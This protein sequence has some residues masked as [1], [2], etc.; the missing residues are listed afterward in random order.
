MLHALRGALRRTPLRPIYKTIKRKLRGAGG[1]SQSDESAIIDRLIAAEDAPLT[2]VEFGFHPEEFNCIGLVKRA[3]GGLLIDG[4]SESIRI[5]KADFPETIDAVTRFL[6]LDNID[7]IRTKFDKLGILSIDVDGNDY[8]F[9]EALID[10]KPTIIV[11]EYNASMGLRSLTVPYDPAFE[12][13]AKHPSGWYHGAS[14][15]ALSKLAARHG[16][17]LAA[18]SSA[19]LNL[20][21][22]RNGKL[23]PATA[24][25]PSTL[26][27]KW[28]GKTVDQQWDAIA[29]LPFVEI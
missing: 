17:G 5:A 13:H 7:F 29:A 1:Q 16:Y 9:L 12:R 14:I 15:T 8:W 4:D 26:R 19:G 10:I 6:T 27:E 23:D 20:F 2:F 28:S 21:F 18:V 11:V 22:T 24:W 25:R 3:E